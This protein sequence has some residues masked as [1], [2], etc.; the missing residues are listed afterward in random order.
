MKDYAR[1]DVYPPEVEAIGDMH[2]CTTEGH[3]FG[4]PCGMGGDAILARCFLCEQPDDGFSARLVTIEGAV[5][6]VCSD[7]WARDEVR[8]PLDY[9]EKGTP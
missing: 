9:T 2:G 6:V 7:C 1:S 3:I 8:V 4:C 5:R